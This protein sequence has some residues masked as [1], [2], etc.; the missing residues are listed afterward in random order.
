MRKRVI[1]ALAALSVCLGP[2]PEVKAQS[3]TVCTAGNAAPFTRETIAVSTSAVGLT[4]AIY[5]PGGGVNPATVALISVQGGENV[6]VWFDGTA[7][8]TSAGIV[9][10]SG[11]SLYICGPVLGTFKAI[12]DDSADSELAVQYFNVAQ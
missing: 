6:R 4:R 1:A 12:R 5:A 11:Q 10:Q 8:T 2:V 7:P 3:S 9:I